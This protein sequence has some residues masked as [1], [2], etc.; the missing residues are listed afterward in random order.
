MFTDPKG[1]SAYTQAASTTKAHITDM[2]FAEEDLI[3][4]IDELTQTSSAG[5]DGVP[6]VF[7]KRCK[8]E[9][10][11]PLYLIWRRC[12]DTG[13]TPNELLVAHVIP[14]HKGNHKGLPAN[15]RPIALTSQ[16]VKIFEKVVRN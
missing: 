1:C 7:L 11:K 2:E 5:P 6:A 8:T 16:L 14:I 10:A 9:I 15:Y 4:S 12:L 3:A 13:V